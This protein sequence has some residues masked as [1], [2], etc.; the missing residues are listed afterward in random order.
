MASQKLSEPAEAVREAF[1]EHGLEPERLTSYGALIAAFN[2][3]F[4]GVLLAARASGRELPRLSAGD[5]A[6]F[7]VATHKLSRTLAKDKVTAALRAPFTEH[8]G[9]GEAG[10]AEVRERPRGT[11]LRRSIGELV[12]CPYCLDQWV[13]AGFVGGSIFAPRATRLV[14]GVFTTVALADF[15]QIAYRAGQKQL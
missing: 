11:G 4:A 10:P 13:A 15:L 12:G 3:G 8:A 1:E 14:A 7:G 6:L 9:E 2:A 5:L